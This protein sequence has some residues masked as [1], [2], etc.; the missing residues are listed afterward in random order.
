MSFGH[1]LIPQL[2]YAFNIFYTL[3]YPMSKISL[4]LLYRR[5]FILQWF[6]HACWIMI[7][8][9]GGYALST[10]FVDI[11]ITIPIN[12][13]WNT[14]VEPRHK[15]DTIVLYRVNA[16]FNIVT[17]VILFILPLTVV[18]RLQMSLARRLGLSAIFGVGIL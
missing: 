6:N 14:S 11:F 1:Q 10:L 2:N 9:F 18:W 12:A 8:I 5:I 3:G 7:F 16:Y 13:Q 4:T 15:I 17:D